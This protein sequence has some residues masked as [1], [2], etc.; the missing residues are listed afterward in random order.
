MPQ[1]ITPLYAEA[2]ILL[3]LWNFTL[4]DITSVAK[5]NFMPGDAPAYQ[6]AL[7][8]LEDEKALTSKAKTTRYNVYSL[9]EEGKARLAEA[10][11][12]PEFIFTAQV[13]AKTANSILNWFRLNSQT[14]AT[15]VAEAPAA[16]ITSYQEFLDETLRI[17][18]EL[19][20]DYN[21]GDLVPI[22][23]IRRAMG[24]R[25]SRPQFR[26]WLLEI[27]AND[28]VQLMGCQESNVSQDQLEDSIMIPG[29][30]LRFYVRR[31]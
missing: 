15:A 4:A 24:D 17:Y 1:E 31:L 3:N 16:P 25:I 14:A 11:A 5:S 21:L 10:M 20:R 26:E 2:R 7:A 13:G 23:R 18:D 12:N 29:N 28:L 8:R 19:N 30:E 22:Y 27:Q 6:E 9:T